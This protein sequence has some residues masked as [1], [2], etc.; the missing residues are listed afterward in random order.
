MSRAK[1]IKPVFIICLLALLIAVSL[2]ALTACDEE[3][4]LSYVETDL[5]WRAPAHSEVIYVIS[6]DDMT[7]QETEMITSLQGLVAKRSASIYIDSDEESEVWLDY[8]S[9]KYGFVVER[10]GDPWQ[11]L[12]MFRA[13]VTDG[14]Y[15]LYDSNYDAAG[16]MFGQS[17][18]YATTVAGAE[19]WLMIPATLSEEA[20]E[21]G[22]VLGKDVRLCNTEE[23]FYEYRD[24]L[25]NSL[26][27][28][29]APERSELR[30]YAIAAGAMCFYSDYYDG[31]DVKD[32]ILSWA[33]ENSP[34]LGWTENEVNFVESN[35]MHSEITIAA[36]W[37]ANLSLYS[38]FEQEESWKQNNYDAT[39]PETE[40]K[41]YVAIV[42]TDGDNLQWMDNGF[43]TDKK[44]FGSEF[45]GDFPMT[46]TIAPG[47]TDLAPHILDYLYSNGTANDQFIAGPSGVGY[48]NA[49]NYNRDSL[50]GYARITASYMKEAGMEYL[51]L[52]DG[53]ADP[54]VLDAFA[55]YDSIKGGVWSVG[56][57]Y[58]EGGG[59]VYWANDKPFVCMRETLWRI[60]GDDDSNR[61][62][63]FVERVAQRINNYIVDP[64]VI[65]GYTVVAAHA[66][67]IG[68]MDYVARFVEQ[69]DEDVEVVTLGQLLQ[70]VA[71]NVRHEDVIYADD[72]MP[73]DITD[74]APISSEQ[75][76]VS[77]IAELETD[78]NRIFMFDGGNVRGYKWQF[79][80]GGL[81]YDSAGYSDEGVTLDGS[82]L[83]DVIDPMPNA[84]MA[85]KFDIGDND[86]FLR[87][88]A[89]VS[90]DADSNMRVRVVWIEN[91]AI[92][93]EVLES[94]DYEKPHS[95]FG[96]YLFDQNSPNVFSYDLSKYRGKTVTISV[97][98]DDTGDGS[99]E[100]I[101]ISRIEIG[102]TAA[103]GG[104]TGAWD[105][106]DIVTYWKKSGEVARHPEGVC[107]E[108]AD[109]AISAEVTIATSELVI[110]MRK[111]DR[112]QLQE[113]DVSAFVVVK[114][115]GNIVRVE[116][117]VSD[118]IEVGNTDEGFGYVYDVSAYVGMK[119]EVE[120]ISITV[121]GKTGDHACI[122]AIRF[123]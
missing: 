59:G 1:I 97:E 51:N 65:E 33:D 74:L 7:A 104:D 11:L 35:S 88:Y 42:M 92:V 36:D 43:A 60:A 2:V 69:L 79:G 30:D 68:S 115:N 54:S 61:Y 112:G 39:V 4:P 98:Q 25:N 101:F 99:G 50:P 105:V 15:V 122:S 57:K 5:F 80:D 84:W 18:N 16:S 13:Y 78:E 19:G 113:P 81:Q 72:I 66:W 20:E 3:Q 44:Y 23:I 8:V 27:I 10:I 87:L 76:H 67:S 6:T 120:I 111:F 83:E 86:N 32:E 34:I 116:D 29:Q 62:Y 63:G 9:E 53:A 123:V 82:D 55:A 94:S 31:S 47:M 109:A 90:G 107:L 49:V 12:D 119:A 93:S 73:E 114:V 95:E 117:A 24:R 41:H 71:R 58:I 70:L 38:S 85:D 100:Q 110:Y 26:L 56:D 22:F 28:H 21:A 75:Y 77:Q 14:K 37:S 89:S 106:S 102:D 17:I 64:T 40:D 118:Y 96:W 91:G 52:L 103:D 48:V 46:W 45:R 121:N 108:G